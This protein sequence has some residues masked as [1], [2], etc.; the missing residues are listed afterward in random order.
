MHALRKE[1][2]MNDYSS[3]PDEFDADADDL[4]ID[5]TEFEESDGME[6]ALEVELL[7]TRM[8]GTRFAGA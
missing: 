8:Q 7:L 5:E 3:N 2:L 6:T 1:I 4:P